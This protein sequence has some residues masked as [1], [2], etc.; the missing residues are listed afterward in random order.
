MPRVLH[1]GSRLEHVFIGLL[2]QLAT[3]NMALSLGV[4]EITA[5]NHED[6]GWCSSL[7]DL[8][9]VGQNVACTLAV[10][11]VDFVGGH[12]GQLEGLTGSGK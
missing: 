12:I 5:T 8:E 2:E 11:T 3:L 6:L 9:I 1:V 4:I 10:L 7:H